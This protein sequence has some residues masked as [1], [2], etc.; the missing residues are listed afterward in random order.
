MSH[1]QRSVPIQGDVSVC[2]DNFQL[3]SP[4]SSTTKTSLT[5]DYEIER[6]LYFLGRALYRYS[7]LQRGRDS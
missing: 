4:D 5:P 7:Q 3:G 2:A 6:S 1:K